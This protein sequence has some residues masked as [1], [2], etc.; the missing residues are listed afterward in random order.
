MMSDM[1]IFFCLYCAFVQKVECWQKITAAGELCLKIAVRR[2][3]AHPNYIMPL[4]CTR[5]VR[6]WNLSTV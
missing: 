5:R 1:K 2:N 3:T 6:I 4:N